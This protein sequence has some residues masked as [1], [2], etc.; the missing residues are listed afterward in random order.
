MRETSVFLQKTFLVKLYN[1]SYTRQKCPILRV[2]QVNVFA[3][4]W[5]LR[6]RA[7]AGLEHLFCLKTFIVRSYNKSSDL[8]LVLT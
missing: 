7:W 2:L 5:D 6:G 3:L 1:K 8:K 4:I